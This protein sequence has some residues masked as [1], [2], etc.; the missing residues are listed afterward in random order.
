MSKQ[1]N[2]LLYALIVWLLFVAGVGAAMLW[3][4]L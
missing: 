2:W 3:V 1:R 4:A